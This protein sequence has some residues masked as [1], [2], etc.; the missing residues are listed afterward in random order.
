VLSLLLST[1]AIVLGTLVGLGRIDLV[2][3]DA[4]QSLRTRP[5]PEDNQA[6]CAVRDQGY[7]I[8]EKDQA[9]LFQRFAR[10][11][12]AGQPQEKGIGLGLAFVKTVVARHDGRMS[13]TSKPGAGSEFGFVLPPRKLLAS[14]SGPAL[15]PPP[16]AA[17]SSGS[18]PASTG[19][20]RCANAAT[21]YR[22]LISAAL[23]P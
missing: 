20:A 16:F 9:R 15:L 17:P 3:Y 14:K 10:F 4:V 2:L 12:A 18:A 22:M 11:S 7:G 23:R 6:R 19:P 13:V 21:G 1:L 5:V 8:S